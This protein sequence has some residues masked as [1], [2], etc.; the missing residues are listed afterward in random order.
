MSSILQEIENSPAKLHGRY[1]HVKRHLGE[2]ICER[3]LC[4]NSCDSKDG[5]QIDELVAFKAQLFL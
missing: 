1:Q 2:E 5:L 3:Q 4:H